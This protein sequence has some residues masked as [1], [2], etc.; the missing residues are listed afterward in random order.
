M[1]G[2]GI[3][4]LNFASLDPH[5]HPKTSSWPEEVIH[6]TQKALE[7]R[8]IDHVCRLKDQ[9]KDIYKLFHR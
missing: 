2:E 6:H 5:N 4:F 9:Q 7:D 8:N 1:L 3:L